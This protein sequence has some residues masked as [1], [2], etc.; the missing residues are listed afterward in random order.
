[1]SSP[2]LHDVTFLTMR[3]GTVNLAINFLTPHLSKFDSIVCTGV[4][5]MLLAPIVAH[6]L[7]KNIVVVRKEPLAKAHAAGIIES[8]TGIYG[9]GRYVMID[10]I[11]ESGDT[12]VRA[13]DTLQYEVD[14]CIE[15]GDRSSAYYADDM[16]NLKYP[17]MVGLYLYHYAGV[18]SDF[19]HDCH[20]ETVKNILD[21]LEFTNRRY[22]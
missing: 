12:L 7:N 9:V 2:Y 18:C 17:K 21:N 4:S 19:L 15:N 20:K 6:L 10:D 13:V 22:S 3:P 8:G 11:I 5:G 14:K 16:R 1:M